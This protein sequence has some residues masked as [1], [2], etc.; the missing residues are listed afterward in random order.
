MAEVESG[1]PASR[2]DPAAP[3]SLTSGSA[4]AE[5][6]E[7]V[8]RSVAAGSPDSKVANL[9]SGNGG[10]RLPSALAAKWLN[11]LADERSNSNKALPPEPSHPRSAACPWLRSN[12]TGQPTPVEPGHLPHRAPDPAIT[13][14]PPF[15][16]YSG[17]TRNMD[18]YIRARP[19]ARSETRFPPPHQEPGTGARPCPR[20][21]GF[22]VAPGAIELA[23]AHVL[24]AGRPTA[25][26]TTQRTARR[27]PG[28]ARSQR[29]T[30]PRP[31]FLTGGPS[32]P[33]WPGPPSR[34]CR[35]PPSAR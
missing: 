18:V 12:G 9:R 19:V 33:R 11:S 1:T 14:R 34:R 27:Q 2:G 25:S 32:W 6:C 21:P 24:D 20:G 22:L 26:R 10:R 23:Q 8:H 35:R 13:P 31:A 16:A 29:R 15:L 30:R 7:D 4:Q 3:A 28:P 5:R 17:R